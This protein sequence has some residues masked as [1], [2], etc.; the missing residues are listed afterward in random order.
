MKRGDLY[1]R[2]VP[3]GTERRLTRARG[4]DVTNGLAEFV[5]QEEMDRDEGYWWSPDG[6]RIAYAEVDESAVERRMLST[7]RARR[8]RARRAPTRAPARPTPRS[9]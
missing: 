1:V 2:A 3:G 6:R 4:R 7:R 8:G 9:A 5:A